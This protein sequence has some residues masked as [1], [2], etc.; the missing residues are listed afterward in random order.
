M[1]EIESSVLESQEHRDLLDIV[2]KLCS[3]GVSR[4]IDLPQIVVCGDQS[5]G[6][7]S[8]LDAISGMAFPAKD[9]VCTRFARGYSPPGPRGGGQLLHRTSS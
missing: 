8:V 1:K 7:S 9:N 3:G 5:S 6:K 4:Y 2:D